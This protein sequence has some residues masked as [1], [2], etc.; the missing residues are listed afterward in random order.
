MVLPAAD[1]NGPLCA[2]EQRCASCTRLPAPRVTIVRDLLEWPVMLKNTGDGVH[3]IEKWDV[4]LRVNS[5][6]Q[7]FCPL[8]GCIQSA[9][10]SH[11]LRFVTRPT[12]R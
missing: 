8:L 9:C 4:R 1:A 10:P 2:F 11:G 3:V 5:M 7:Q 6:L 12:F